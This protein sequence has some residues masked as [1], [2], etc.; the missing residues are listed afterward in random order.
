MTHSSWSAGLG[1]MENRTI[2]AAVYQVDP[3]RDPRWAAFLQGHPLASVFHTPGWLE[4]LRRTYG[5]EAVAYTTTPPGIELTNG[6]V[7]CRVYSPITGRRLVSLPFSDHCE[8]LVERAEDFASLIHSLELDRISER[9]KYL[10]LRPRTA[11]AVP[12]RG[13]EPAQTYYF[14]CADLTPASEDIFRRLHKNSTQQPIR[15]AEREG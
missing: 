9:W 1:H 14:H 8:P 15:R 10:E 3:Y 13:L 4:A 5:Y 6:I 7:V 2:R 12:P 11:L